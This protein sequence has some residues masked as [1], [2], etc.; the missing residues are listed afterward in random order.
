MAKEKQA[1]ENEKFKKFF[2]LVNRS[3]LRLDCGWIVNKSGGRMAKNVEKWREY[4]DKMFVFLAKESTE[5]VKNRVK[6]CW[7]S[8]KVEVYCHHCRD[9]RRPDPWK[10]YRIK[11]KADMIF[12]SHVQKRQSIREW[13]LS[14]RGNFQ[15]S[16]QDLTREFDPG[17]GRTLAACLTHASRAGT[18]RSLL[19]IVLAADG[20]VTREQPASNRGIT[21]RKMC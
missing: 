2:S 18:R 20:W 16:I 6:R 17:S 1:K 21:H 15:D 10:R 9:E 3:C 5:A 14:L 4:C 8:G 11:K 12:T 13:V 19:R 7:Q